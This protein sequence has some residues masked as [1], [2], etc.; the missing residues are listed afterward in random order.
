MVHLGP[1][2]ARPGWPSPPIPWTTNSGGIAR[3]EPR[4]VPRGGPLAGAHLRSAVTGKPGFSA[5]PSLTRQATLATSKPDL[6][7]SDTGHRSVMAQTEAQ[8]RPK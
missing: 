2:L 1:M 7:I 4:I 6:N 5:K 8:M 3:P